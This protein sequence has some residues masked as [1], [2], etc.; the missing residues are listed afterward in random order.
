MLEVPHGVGDLS[1]QW[2]DRLAGI[3]CGQSARGMP[4]L[5]FLVGEFDL[6]IANNLGMGCQVGI[7]RINPLEV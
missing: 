3:P 5:S 2:G 6:Q 1:D 4:G 7:V